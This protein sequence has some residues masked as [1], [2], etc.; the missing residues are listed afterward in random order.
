[1]AEE[2]ILLKM[3]ADYGAES[4][5]WDD[6]GRMIQL[7]QLPLSD[8]LRRELAAWA[9]RADWAEWDALNA[10]AIGQSHEIDPDV[11]SDGMTLWLRTQ[12]ELGPG[13]LVEWRD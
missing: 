6:R 1:V 9:R 4:P 10:Y 7:D 12:E 5:L 13:Y 3:F 8:D 11:R 2:R